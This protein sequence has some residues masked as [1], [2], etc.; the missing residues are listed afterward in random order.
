MRVHVDRDRCGEHGQC[1]IAAP[2][3]FSFDDDGRLLY[4]AEPDEGLRPLAEDAADVCPN[5]S[6]RDRRMNMDNTIGAHR[7]RNLDEMTVA[8]LEERIRE[9]GVEFIYY[10]FVSINGRVLGKV[11]PARHLRRNLEKGVQFHGSAISDLTIG[12]HTAICSEA[13]PWRRS[14]RRSP[15]PTRSRCCPGTPRSGGSSAALYR[16]DDAAVDPGDPSPTDTRGLLFRTLE[17]FERETGLE[18][19]S[20]CEPEMTLARRVDRRRRAARGL[21]CLPRRKSRARATG[22]PAG[23]PLRPGDG[24]RDGRG[25]L[26]GQRPVRAQL[27]VRPRRAHGRPPH[28]VPPDLPAGRQR[29]RRQRD[30]HAEAVHRRHGQRLPPQPVALAGRRQPVRRARTARPACLRALP[31]TRSAASSSTPPEGMAIYASTV[32]SYKRYWDVGLFAPTHVDWGLDNR[33]CTVRVQR[34]WPS[35]V[36]APGRDRQSLP[37]AHGAPGGDRARPRERDSTRVRRCRPRPTRAM[38]VTA[39]LRCR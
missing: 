36:Q 4:L 34:D 18:L 2:E 39:S 11:V 27:H 31:A 20:G 3:I 33:T 16:R 26:R 32:N 14:S 38:P 8:A 29:A 30:V 37:L 17:A 7:A 35:R 22:L 19:R 13:V 10:Q 28:D 24:P 15:M 23:H 1:V 12:S 5:R 21:S 6:D 25:R 9:A